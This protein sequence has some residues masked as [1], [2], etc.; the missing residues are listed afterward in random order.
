ME[1]HGLANS[2]RVDGGGI[3]VRPGPL[4]DGRRLVFA[5][6]QLPVPPEND[7]RT[8]IGALHGERE[9]V[10]MPLER[11]ASDGMGAVEVVGEPSKRRRR[12][13]Q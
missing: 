5:G 13:L 1:A 8:A 12:P 10:G 9:Y 4:D 2:Q 3:V 7:D 6:E 11:D